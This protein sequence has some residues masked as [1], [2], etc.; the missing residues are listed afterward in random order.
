MPFCLYPKKWLEEAG[1]KCIVHCIQTLPADASEAISS[2]PLQHGFIFCL[3]LHL[4]QSIE[5]RKGMKA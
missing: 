2:M 1:R 4:G 3:V 5:K